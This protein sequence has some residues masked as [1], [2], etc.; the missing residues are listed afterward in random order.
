MIVILVIIIHELAHCMV[1]IFF[2]VKVENIELFF[3][4]GVIKSEKTFVVNPQKEILISIA[5]PVSNLLM[6]LVAYVINCYIYTHELIYFFITLNLSIGIFN[7]IPILPLDGG[8]IL[9]ALI[10]IVYNRN[11]ATYVAVV[12]GKVLCLAFLVIGIFIMVE[13]YVGFIIII[14][15]IFLHTNCHNE[16]KMAPYTHM[17][18]IIMKQINYDNLTIRNIRE[19]E[20]ATVVSVLKK[21][22]TGN[23]CIISVF[24]K[25]GRY[26]G[27]LTEK[28]ILEAIINHDSMLTLGELIKMNNTLRTGGK[29]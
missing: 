7:M 3:F 5:G 21:I 10:N 12:I 23:Y 25:R 4:G 13:S 29:K 16:K 28:Q 17:R 11:K 19:Y 1:S 27:E 26:L 20:C 9:R 18:D 8:R 6:F 22:T 14:F 24:S 2:S 15:S